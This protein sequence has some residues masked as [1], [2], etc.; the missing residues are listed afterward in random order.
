MIK[1][2]STA[3]IIV[4]GVNI[5]SD[6]NAQVNRGNTSHDTPNPSHLADHKLPVPWYAARIA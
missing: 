6:I 4:L 5:D 2:P 3:Q 1:A